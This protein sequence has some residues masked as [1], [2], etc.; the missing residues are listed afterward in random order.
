MIRLARSFHHHPYSL[1]DD[2]PLRRHRLAVVQVIIL[3]LHLTARTTALVL[4]IPWG[5]MAVLKSQ[6]LLAQMV[7]P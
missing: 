2:Y 5:S 7:Y 3:E 4:E 1:L 6:S